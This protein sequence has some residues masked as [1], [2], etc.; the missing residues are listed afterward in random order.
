MNLQGLRWVVLGLAVAA[1]TVE[2]I[3]QETDTHVAASSLVGASRARK[4]AARIEPLLGQRLAGAHS[5]A[6]A[7]LGS[8]SVDP[9]RVVD[10]TSGVAVSVFLEGAS[11]VQAVEGEEARV[12]AHVRPDT[13]LA[14]VSTELGAEDLVLLDKAPAQPRVEFVVD[15]SD[16]VRGLRRVGGVIELLDAGGA[17][18]LRVRRPWVAFQDGD[19]RVRRQAHL[20]LE[21]CD[22]DT[23]PAAPWGRAVVDPG[24]RQCRLAVTWDPADVRFPLLVDPLWEIS[25]AMAFPRFGHTASSLSSGTRFLITGGSE[26]PDAPAELF[27]AVTSTWAVTGVPIAERRHHAAAVANNEVLLM[28]G[29]VGGVLAASTEAYLVAQG[30][31]EARDPLAA[32]RAGIVAMIDYDRVWAIGGRDASGPV[33]TVEQSTRGLGWAAWSPLLEPRLGHSVQ[34]LE[35]RLVVA[36]GESGQGAT[37]SAELYNVAVPSGESV[38]TAPLAAPRAHHG[39]VV[40]FSGNEDRLYVIGGEGAAGPVSSIERYDTDAGTWETLPQQ[41]QVPRSRFA[42]HLRSFV[43]PWLTVYGGVGDGGTLPSLV[44]VLHF[45]PAGLAVSTAGSLRTPRR[46]AA[47]LLYGSQMSQKDQPAIAGG[48]DATGG[49]LSSVE[50]LGIGRTGAC[51]PTETS[52]ES[53]SQ[54]VSGV[55]LDGLCCK[56][57]TLGVACETDYECDLLGGA[58]CVDGYCCDAACEGQCEACD[59]PGREGICVPAT[60]APHGER[61]A[62]EG[63]GSTC[64]ETCNGKDRSACHPASYGTPCGDVSCDGHARRAKVCSG[65]GQCVDALVADPC[66]P[67]TCAAGECR[68]S[69]VTEADCASGFTCE[70]GRCRTTALPACD[71][72]TSLYFADGTLADDCYPYRCKFGA[73][74]CPTSCSPEGSDCAAGAC[75]P[76]NQCRQIIGEKRKGCAVAM[77]EPSPSSALLLWALGGLLAAVRRKRRS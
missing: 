10:K 57:P 63:D 34:R 52:C 12:F 35:G 44:E 22:A 24:A 7:A 67:Y 66:V 46:D 50:R 76:D 16:A 30:T 77:P 53:D 47:G 62:C 17:P 1:C 6:H 48:L 9:L 28:G 19:T 59:V 31:F 65:A 55:C 39:A 73:S 40:A 15:L 38:A 18:R 49:V 27:D 33:P 42:M 25:A 21:G 43:D 51:E 8:T 5:S 72:F 14:R 45:G 54:C 61:P 29:E 64:S 41:L 68:T 74:V 32:P 2:T 36:G 3:V 60:G 69:C 13:H 71:G 75:A 23:S 11:T 70:D 26:L 58:R 4:V 20:E 37:A 56:R